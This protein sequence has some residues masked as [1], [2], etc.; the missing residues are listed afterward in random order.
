MP[1]STDLKALRR[2]AGLSQDRAASALAEHGIDVGL[3]TFAGWERGENEPDAFKQTAVIT[4]LRLLAEAEKKKAQSFA[5]NPKEPN[6]V[7][8]A[9]P[10][11]PVAT[12]REQVEDAFSA[13]DV[14]LRVAAGDRVSEPSPRYLPEL[15]MEHRDKGTLAVILGRIAVDRQHAPDAEGLFAH[16]MPTAAFSD[17]AAGSPLYSQPCADFAGAGYYEISL[18]GHPM[19]VNLARVPG[20]GFRLRMDDDGPSE[21]VDPDG[22]GGWVDRASGRPCS[23]AILALVLQSHRVHAAPLR[24]TG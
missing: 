9:P 14:Q 5:L 10:L 6:G 7:K 16:R 22:E 20:G 24:R 21:Y 23:F 12:L 15:R 13:S 8:D 17:V 11:V 4:A 2:E 1:F 18:D 19:V 3:R